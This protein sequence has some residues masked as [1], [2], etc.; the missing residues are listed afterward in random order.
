MNSTVPPAH[1]GRSATFPHGGETGPA[2]NTAENLP[3]GLASRIDDWRAQRGPELAR[4]RC[5]P[6]VLDLHVHGAFGWDFSWGDPDRIETMLDGLLA[7]GVT[8]LV[9]TLIT[10]D[11]EA[12]LRALQDIAVVAQRRRRPPAILG[13]YLEGPF[14]SVARRGSHPESQLWS[15]S[16][17]G[18]ADD[19]KRWQDAAGGLIRLMTLAPEL[20]GAFTLA[21]HAAK[22]GIRVV[23]GHT[24]ADHDIAKRAL[25]RGFNH[26]THLFNA[27]RPFTHRD[28]T[29]VSAVLADRHATVEIIADGFHVFPPV[30]EMVANVIGPDRLVLISDGICPMGL[31]NGGHRAYG[32]EISVADGR[33][34]MQ[35]TGQLVGGIRP[36]LEGLRTLHQATA[37]PPATLIG[38]VSQVPRRVLG[39]PVGGQNIASAHDEVWVDHRWNW[40]ATRAQ[41]QWYWC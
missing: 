40:V 28:P 20:E 23:L 19:L 26:V 18:V 4:G 24:D 16:R 2:W 14:L 17:A 13:V 37:I 5:L 34:T 22:L 9:A 8:G 1:N 36:L 35:E 7:T 21:E 30:V 15:P 27:M 33:C 29:A 41:N 6:G 32:L 39:T 25:G 12:R 11:E 3:A 10:C 38:A 31:G